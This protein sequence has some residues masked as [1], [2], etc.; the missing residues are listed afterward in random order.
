M[1]LHRTILVSIAVIALPRATKAAFW[2]WG[3]EPSKDGDDAK[4]KPEEKDDAKP[5]PD[6]MNNMKPRPDQKGDE[7]P[8]PVPEPEQ[9]TP[10][11]FSEFV[12]W[13][14]S[15]GGFVDERITIGYEPGTNRGLV[16]AAPIRAEELI[17]RTPKNLILSPPGADMCQ[18]IKA[19]THE[20]KDGAQSKWHTYFE[21]DITSETDMHVPTEWDRRS[22]AMMELQGLP[23]SGDTH[24]HVDWYQNACNKGGGMN[25]LDMK[26][27]MIWLTRA[28]DIGLVPMYD[29]MNHH[30]GLVNTY[31][32]TNQEGDLKVIA[33]TDIGENEQVFSTYARAGMESTIDIFN[34][35]GFVE[36]Y[37]QLWRWNDEK[38]MVSSRDKGS[39][40]HNRYG[41][42]NADA[43]NDPADR[44][45][46]EPNSDHYEVLVINESLAA[47][48]P[49]KELV[50]ILGNGQRS[51]EE[52]RNY[53]HAHHSN[54]WSSHVHALHDSA[55][56]ILNE[57]P[58]TIEEDELLVPSEKRRL[59]KVRRVGRVDV[60][61][62]DAIQAIEYRLAFKKA[63][64]LAMEV[65][66]KE[67]FLV[68]DEL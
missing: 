14:R 21:Y 41:M 15:H 56:A 4:Q 48:S 24:R 9:S 35:Y 23:P 52:W 2:S 18:R 37:P 1:R 66:E 17:I 63:L 58:T 50:K 55:M 40:T 5:K 45:R 6:E 29:L 36:D 28:T 46:F 67:K 8:K 53:I 20:L 57:L 27:L 51:F 61:K 39:H 11:E 64:R 10:L 34:T 44:L 62:Q 16:A 19:A 31:F 59:E 26:A 43:N 25:D 33:S 13:F 65:A 54:L 22:R 30:N 42:N 12:D 60:N 47:L 7:K 68:S 38:L 3:S 32:E 49:T